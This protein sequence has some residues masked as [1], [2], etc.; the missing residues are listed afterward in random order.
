MAVAVLDLNRAVQVAREKAQDPRAAALLDQIAARRNQKVTEMNRFAELCDR[1]DNLYYPNE[2]TTGGASHWAQYA[3]PGRPHVSINA[4]PTYVE[5]PAAL[6]SVEPVENMVSPGDS[7]TLRA[8]TAAVERLY[9]AWKEDVEFELLAHQAAIVK[10]LYG[11]TAGKVYWDDENKR[12]GISIVDQPRNLWLGWSSTDY[13]KLDWVLY[14]YRIGADAAQ[15]DWGVVFEQGIGSDGSKFPVVRPFG[16]QGQDGMLQE[17]ARSWLTEEYLMAEVYDYWYKVPTEKTQFGRPTKFETRNAI[18]IGNLLVQDEAHR[19]YGGRMPYVPLFNTYIPGV[20]DGRPEYYDIEQLLREKDERMTAGAQMI[21]RTVTGQFWQLVGP[22][23]PLSISPGLKPKADEVIAPGAGNRIEAIQPWMPEF[24]LEQYLNRLDRDL[25]DVSGLN[26]LLRGLAPASVLSSSKAI[27]SLVANYETRIR[28]KR[29]LLYRWRKGMWDL[30]RTIWA[31]KV[32]VE[33]VAEGLRTVK[34]I[35]VTPPNLTP[36]DDM[37]AS[38]I[39]ANLTNNKLWSARRAM[40]R[41]VVDDPEQEQNIIREEQTDATLNPAAVQVM[42][43]LLALLQQLGIQQ[44]GV[45]QMVQS[46]AQSL[47]AVRGLQPAQAGTQSLN[48]PAEQVTRRPDQLPANAQGGAEGDKAL[49][50]TQIKEGEPSNRILTQQ[51]IAG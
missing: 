1:W 36:R 4:Y 40:D 14:T 44:Q 27:A 45:D 42:A 33:P 29:D 11:R 5:V 6:Q 21:S 28:M 8:L 13:R 3:K 32:G 22:E 12:P 18:F 35:E 46:Q 43:Q 26:D 19:E 37:E 15:E 31:E 39:A 34:R 20:P 47:A 50:Q 24:Q 38:Q 48:A 51:N 7:P 9:F 23:A 41:V 49:L 16:S 10:A 17:P 30:A 2:F 25:T